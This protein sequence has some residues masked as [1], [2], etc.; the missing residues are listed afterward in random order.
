MAPSILDDFLA[1]REAQVVHLPITA[2][3]QSCPQDSWPWKAESE[4]QLKELGPKA[5]AY[6]PVL[7][8]RCPS[9]KAKV[10]LSA[11]QAGGQWKMGPPPIMEEILAANR[12]AKPF[13]FRTRLPG[14]TGRPA[15]ISGADL[16]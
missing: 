11:R 7:P 13:G 3:I 9:L 10:G 4:R 1:R 5:L 2:R 14:R 8:G 15:H 16:D 6:R 12:S